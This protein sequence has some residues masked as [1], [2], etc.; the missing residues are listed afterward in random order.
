M[1]KAE[2]GGQADLRKCSGQGSASGTAAWAMRL[3]PGKPL[4]RQNQLKTN[5]QAVGS[6]KQD[7]HRAW[8]SEGNAR[9]RNKGKNKVASQTPYKPR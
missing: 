5:L 4:D 2:K 7:H 8:V 6:L 9:R 3:N 1:Q